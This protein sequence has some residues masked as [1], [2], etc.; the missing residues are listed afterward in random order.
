M[1]ITAYTMRLRGVIGGAGGPSIA[2]M[3]EP[4]VR[5]HKVP[6]AGSPCGPLERGPTTLGQL[7]GRRTVGSGRRAS[8]ERR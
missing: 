1:M 7:A 4:H 8:R 2:D 6:T 5:R 3:V